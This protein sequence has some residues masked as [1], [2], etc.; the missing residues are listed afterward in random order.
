M[1][2]GCSIRGMVIEAI[3]RRFERGI[4]MLNKKLK[5][6]LVVFLSLI[7]VTSSLHLEVFA[8]KENSQI[9]EADHQSESSNQKQVIDWSLRGDDFSLS[10]E[11]LEYTVNQR[12][13][14]IKVTNDQIDLTQLNINA[15]DDMVWNY[16]YQFLDTQKNLNIKAG[17]YFTFF[18]PTQYFIVNSVEKAIDLEDDNG[19][20]FASYTVQDNQIIVVFQESLSQVDVE[21]IQGTIKLPVQMNK[22]ALKFKK[23]QNDQLQT[24]VNTQISLPN[25]NEILMTLPL[26]IDDKDNDIATQNDTNSQNNTIFALPQ[27]SVTPIESNGSAHMQIIWVDNHNSLNI[28][29]DIRDH[30]ILSVIGISQNGKQE[31]FDLTS[32]DLDKLGLT[33]MPTIQMVDDGV[34][35]CQYSVNNLPSKLNINN[36]QWDITY[37]LKYDNSP[38]DHYMMQ[39]DDDGQLY[40][41]IYT[42]FQSTLSFKN[43]QTLSNDFLDEGYLKGKITIVGKVNDVV[44]SSMVLNDMTQF[45]NI[46]GKDDYVLSLNNFP[47]Y[48]TK[49]QEIVYRIIVDND[50]NLRI[51][52]IEEGDHVELIYDNTH[53]TNHSSQSDAGYCNGT[54]VL[55]LQ[56]ETSYNAHKYWK[57]EN[58]ELRPSGELRLWRYTDRDGHDYMSASRVMIGDHDVHMSLDTAQDNYDIKFYDTDGNLYTLPKY[59]ADG[60]KYVYF[61][62]ETMD[63]QDYAQ[64]IKDKQGNL[65]QNGDTAIYDGYTIENVRTK[66][67]E[68]KAIKNWIAAAEQGILKDVQVNLILQRKLKNVENSEWVDFKDATLDHFSSVYTSDSITETVDQFNENGQEYIYR[69]VEKSVCYNNENIDILP[70]VSSLPSSFKMNGETYLSSTQTQQDDNGNVTTQIDN[71]L[72]GTVNYRIEKKWLDK[73]GIEIENLEGI[74]ASINLYYDLNQEKNQIC[75]SSQDLVLDGK[76]DDKKNVEFEGKTITIEDEGWALNI[77]GLPKF[78]D[79]GYK[80]SYL[81]QEDALSNGW[82]LDQENHQREDNGD[83][84]TTFVNKKGEGPINRIKVQKRWN[85]DGDVKFRHPVHISVYNADNKKIGEGIL[86]EDHNWWSWIYLQ[87]GEV[88]DRIEED[89]IDDHETNQEQFNGPL[90]ENQIVTDHHV[91]NVTYSQEDDPVSKGDKTWIVTNTRIGYVDYSVQKIW[92]DQLADVNQRPKA[93]FVLSCDSTDYL[94]SDD[95]QNLDNGFYTANSIICNKVEESGLKELTIPMTKTINISEDGNYVFENLPKY[96]K[97][98]KVIHYQI[99][100]QWADDNEKQKAKDNNFQINYSQSIYQ[101]G[102]YDHNDQQAITVTNQRSYTKDVTFHKV[103]I[104]T[105]AFENGKRPDIFLRLYKTKLVDGQEQLMFI[106]EYTP[107]IWEED[108]DMAVH[109]ENK[110]KRHLYMWKCTFKNL[111]KYDEN[112]YEIKYFA[113]EVIVADAVS[114]DYL[115]VECYASED[116]IANQNQYQ[117]PK[118]IQKTEDTN[119]IQEDGYF[120]NRL[121]GNVV[122]NGKKIWKNISNNYPSDQIPE[123]NIRLY[124]RTLDSQ[125]KGEQVNQ[126]TLSDNERV[127]GTSQ[128]VFTFQN[129]KDIDGNITSETLPKYDSIGRKNEYYIEES[130]AGVD[131][132]NEDFVYSSQYDANTFT[133]TNAYNVDEK[134][135]LGKIT[136]EKKWIGDITKYP[137]VTFKIQRRYKKVNSQDY[138]QPEGSDTPWE[139]VESKT[140]SSH[141][142]TEGATNVEF[143]QLPAYA[144]NKEVYE[145]RVIEQSIDGYQ[146]TVQTT[147]SIETNESQNNVSDGVSSSIIQLVKNNNQAWDH[148]VTYTN[149]YDDD[150]NGNISLE[151]DKKW[152]DYDNTFKT[153]PDGIS[154][155][156]KRYADSQDGQNNAISKE[157]VELNDNNLHWNNWHYTITGLD[158]YAPNGKPWKYE[159]VETNPTGYNKKGNQ[160]SIS[161]KSVKNNGNIEM[162]D[163][164]NT[165]STSAKV[166]K[167]WTNMNKNLKQKFAS[168]VRLQIKVGDQDNWQ[169]ASEYF[170]S[171][172]SELPKGFIKPQEAMPAGEAQLIGDSEITFNQLPAGY[173]DSGQWEDYQYRIVEYKISDIEEQT[174]MTINVDNNEIYTSSSNRFNVTGTTANGTTTITNHYQNDL[175]QLKLKKIW[176]D[177]DNAYDTRVE[178]RFYV[179]RKVGNGE[180][181][182]VPGLV[183]NHACASNCKENDYCILV[184]QLPAYSPSGEQYY[185]RFVEKKTDADK[186]KN[187]NITV[188]ENN[189]QAT[190][191]TSVGNRYEITYNNRQ[192]NGDDPTQEGVTTT[193]ITNTLTPTTNVSVTK[194]WEDSAHYPEKGIN[195]KLIQKRYNLSD[196]LMSQEEQSVT[197]T[198]TQARPSYTWEGLPVEIYNNSGITIG[199]YQYAVEELTYVDGYYPIYSQEQADESITWQ[200]TNTITHFSIKKVN[201]E[202]E[203]LSDAKLKIYHYDA[204]T[205][206]KGEVAQSLSTSQNQVNDIERLPIGTYVLV[207]EDAPEGYAKAEPIYFELTRENKIQLIGDSKDLEGILSYDKNNVYTITMTDEWIQVPVQVKKVLSTTRQ[208]IENVHFKI[209]DNNKNPVEIDGQ[210]VFLTDGNGNL[211]TE[212]GKNIVLDKGS[213]QLKEIECQGSMTC[214]ASPTNVYVDPNNSTPFTITEDDYKDYKKDKEKIKNIGDASGNIENIPMNG[215]ITLQKYDSTSNEGIS[216]TTFELKRKDVSNEYK[217]YGEYVSDKDG[218]LVIENLEKGHYQ[219]SEKRS[220]VGYHLED[221]N[222]QAFSCEFN[223]TNEDHEKILSIDKDNQKIN[224]TSGS[225]LLTKNGLMNSRVLGTLTLYKEDADTHKALNDVT[226]T[227]MKKK[228]GQWSQEK[229]WDFKTGYQYENIED[230]KG[231]KILNDDGTYKDGTLII[232]NLEWGQYKIVETGELDGYK[233]EDISFEFDIDRYNHKYSLI[234]SNTIKNHK[235]SLTIQKVD[236]DTKEPLT[237]ARFKLINSQNQTVLMKIDTDYKKAEV[238]YKDEDKNGAVEE[239]EI[240]QLTLEGLKKGDYTLE[241]VQAPEGYVQGED[242][243]FTMNSDGT[244]TSKDAKV[245]GLTIVA[246]NKKSLLTLKK[247]DE[248]NELLSNA[249][250]ALYK[251]EESEPIWTGTSDS[252]DVLEIEKILTSSKIEKNIPD[253]WYVLKEESVPEGYGKAKDIYLYCDTDGMIYQTNKK[254]HHQ[255]QWKEI[256]DELNVVNK[257]IRVSLK[258]VNAKN[259]CLEGAEFS[260]TGIFANET[261]EQTIE[262]I[263]SLKDDSILINASFVGGHTYILKEIKAPDGYILADDIELRI[264]EYGQLIVHDKKI[265]DNCLIIEDDTT[266]VAVSKIDASSQKELAGA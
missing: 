128:F 205:N 133:F 104:D 190:L 248:N 229:T 94:S 119:Y 79:E 76:A 125:D 38:I 93:V 217:T 184:N 167:N 254:P 228:D 59:D 215:K 181:I 97:Q 13:E 9:V 140:I 18:I 16:H 86:L 127:P 116:D 49:G 196:Q 87:D 72:I 11:S 109:P 144:P 257:S 259:E 5:W 84:I 179:Q 122:I 62:R 176:D 208:G 260:I 46:E 169:N 161:Q 173:Y 177:H 238:V 191:I 216:G 214:S 234:D 172:V 263:V 42:S 174:R 34:G 102:E 61:A 211:V 96:D 66:K 25:Q 1:V 4:D 143:N 145:Y 224:V 28:R 69:Y 175:K 65:V 264:N 63:T 258:K 149:T 225:S 73:N 2:Q 232:N 251:G 235:N 44:V 43:G 85:D 261:T 80:Y 124:A 186:N 39:I 138:Y 180:Y 168:Y 198:L 123:L 40:F 262:G 68:Y 105:Y 141:Q 21:K 227:L 101:I 239:F 74:S 113:S 89:F 121:G 10:L 253:I 57:D 159:I 151:G 154:I 27:R 202:G 189:G 112:G 45:H 99:T 75:L 265:K 255:T 6:G 252:Q 146:T 37:E 35:H 36:E 131:S 132:Q 222:G 82:Y 137:K 162:N 203:Q 210:S 209:Y 118:T 107:H 250:F 148:Q 64:F 111:P 92:K 30:F 50:D 195:V 204:K 197:I 88:A 153:R 220:A 117:F 3:I 33:E 51:P 237:S 23:D 256:K 20:V 70:S 241:E 221:I 200:I 91:Y 156:L 150:T 48:T 226:F 77:K 183:Y 185:Y 219:L 53:A 188:V 182:D 24:S 120:L 26:V 81:A 236:V 247:T 242:I 83:H 54:I 199:Y 67:V 245:K 213:Y 187:N 114:F 129:K 142:F 22:E 266:K 160:T 147:E 166:Q 56:G 246:D 212:G 206:Q 193:T 126:M 136:V 47:Q 15:V 103:W 106:N 32:D 12:K 8:E 231:E 207:E 100:E 14:E 19:I 170:Q 171:I 201:T 243:N 249:Q 115:P 17:D 95:R 98:G 108:T 164:T 90:S 41:V 230:N 157:T 78:D 165:L 155:E 71:R 60:Y 55:S 240:G 7:L 158:R 29:P 58:P 130:F 152:V 110:D 134:N 163:L 178:S 233:L 194:E 192:G 218:K 135:V 31:T 139:D 223:I 244:I 52:A